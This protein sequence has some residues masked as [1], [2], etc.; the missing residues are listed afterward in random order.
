MVKGTK[1][2]HCDEEIYDEVLVLEYEG[3]RYYFHDEDC[4]MQWLDE[5]I[6]PFTHWDD[7]IEEY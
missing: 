2:E 6:R 3:Q 5:Q 4:M 7:C 1:C